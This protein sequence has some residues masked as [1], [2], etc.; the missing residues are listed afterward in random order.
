MSK[1]VH[2]Y[3]ES[4]SRFHWIVYSRQLSGAKQQEW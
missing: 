1:Y 4:H 3:K 2:N